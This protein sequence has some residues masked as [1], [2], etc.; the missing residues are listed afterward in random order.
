[1]V[2]GRQGLLSHC[3]IYWAPLP[4]ASF[5]YLPLGAHLEVT[6]GTWEEWPL[7]PSL[8]LSRAQTEATTFHGGKKTTFISGNKIIRGWKKPLAHRRCANMREKLFSLQNM[9]VFFLEKSFPTRNAV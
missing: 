4:P 8:S 9:N 3:N 7:V 6:A 5:L 1:M 2:V